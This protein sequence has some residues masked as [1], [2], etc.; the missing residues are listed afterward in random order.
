MLSA[1]KQKKNK[2][3]TFISADISISEL[4]PPMLTASA[5]NVE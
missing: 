4:F 2:K 3:K 1:K 5:P